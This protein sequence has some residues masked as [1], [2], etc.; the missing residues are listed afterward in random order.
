MA[1]PAKLNLK[2]YQGSTFNEVLRWESSKKIYKSITGISNAAPC[3]ITCA[4]HGVPNGWRIKITNVVGMTD[5]NNTETYHIA[6]KLTSDTIELNAVNSLG[7]KTYISGGVIEYNEPIN[8]TGYTARMQLRAK[9]DDTTTLD[10]YTTEN[11]KLVINT[12]DF[13][14]GLGVSATTTAAYTFNSA[15]YS[16]ELV[17]AGGVVT[18][19]ATGTITLVKEVTR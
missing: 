15:V 5:I 17:S 10:E 6:T 16:L 12:T 9:I 1:S 3:V 14:V 7:Y 8:L 4:S 18:P 13:T 2:I 11:G 19:L